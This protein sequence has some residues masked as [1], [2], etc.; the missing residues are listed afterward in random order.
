MKEQGD[1]LRSNTLHDI[2]NLITCSHHYFILHCNIGAAVFQLVCN[3]VGFL[4]LCLFSFV[5]FFFKTQSLIAHLFHFRKKRSEL[6]CFTGK[7]SHFHPVTRL[8]EA[9]K[10]GVCP[11]CCGNCQAHLTHLPPAPT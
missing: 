11:L 3:V 5:F 2:L 10:A 8:R 4:L 9:I 1:W 7:Q 6:G